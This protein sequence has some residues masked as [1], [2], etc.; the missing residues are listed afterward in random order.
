MWTTWGATWI[1]APVSC[2]AADCEDL[3]IWWEGLATERVDGTEDCDQMAVIGVRLS[4]A[5]SLISVIPFHF[6]RK[7][8]CSARTLNQSPIPRQWSLLMGK[9]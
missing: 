1:T 2:S 5:L 3:R 8:L 9:I 7:Q 6:P 4:P